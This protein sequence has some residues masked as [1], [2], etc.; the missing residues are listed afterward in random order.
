[1][2]QTIQLHTSCSAPL[3]RGDTFGAL[4]LVDY[5]IE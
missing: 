3:V 2:V 5:R 4:L 1:L